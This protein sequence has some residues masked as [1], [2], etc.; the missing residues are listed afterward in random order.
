MIIKNVSANDCGRLEG[1][2]SGAML[3]KYEI[4]KI[5]PGYEGAGLW[6]KIFKK[7]DLGFVDCSQWVANN[8]AAINIW[9]NIQPQTC[10]D[11]KT[12]YRV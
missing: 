4:E 6:E 7:Y 2:P 12:A 5:C 3:L 10:S 1:K 9:N 8:N 11:I